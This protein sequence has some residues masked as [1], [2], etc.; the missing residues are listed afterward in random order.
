MIKRET[1]LEDWFF[2]FH[3]TRFENLSK[4]KLNFVSSLKYYLF[5]IDISKYIFFIPE[6]NFLVCA[7]LIYLPKY[8]RKNLTSFSL[9]VILIPIKFHFKIYDI[10]YLKKYT[11]EAA[12][13][14][15]GNGQQ[16]SQFLLLFHAWMPIGV[17]IT[18]GHPP[19][20]KIIIIIIIF[21]L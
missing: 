10:F 11:R 21:I 18:S 8:K 19:A 1:R 16:A 2:T 5:I 7:I 12:T 14:I 17:K 9:F 20:F 3:K 6:I 13:E 4:D 15:L